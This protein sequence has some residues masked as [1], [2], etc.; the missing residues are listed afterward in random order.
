MHAIDADVISNIVD[1][2]HT[3]TD[4]H[5]H[6]RID[7]PNRLDPEGIQAALRALSGALPELAGRFERRWWRSRWILDP[8]PRWPLE[9]RE[10]EDE[11]RA[12]ALERELFERPFEPFGTLPLTVVLLHLPEHDRLLLRVNHLLAD[13]G[14]TKNLCYRIAECYRM[15]SD[16]PGW[17]P[18]PIRP[19]LFALRVLRSGQLRRLP[20]ALLNLCHELAA[21]RPMRLIHAPMGSGGP[22]T[23]H[24]EALH[25]P[26]ERVLRLR[27]RWK[28]QGVTLNDLALAAF[29]R[30]LVLCFPQANARSTHAALVATADLRQYAPPVHDVCNYSVLR[31]IVFQRLPLPDPTRFVASVHSAA[32]V[33]KEGQV[34]ALLAAPLTPLFHLLPHAWSRSLVAKLL[35]RG[36][37]GPRACAALTN[38]GPIDAE[39]LDFGGG[40]ARAARVLTPVAHAPMLIAALTGCAGTLDFSVGYREP[41]LSR[42]DALRLV[43]TLDREL[44]ALE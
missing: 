11:E 32:R 18:S 17:V 14:G 33:W 6:V 29:S 12:E 4:T 20:W 24:Y 23:A 36:P 10:V 38:I 19:G 22:S 16:D 39:A 41:Q 21:N 43:A 7:V 9:E 30:A 27:R 42:T 8:E 34:G 1:G 31:P 15:L 3:L 25:L 35:R 2:I 28:A 40:P 13:G 37:S 44:S 5:L 26:A